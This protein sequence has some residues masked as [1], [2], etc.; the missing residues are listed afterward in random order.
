V[1]KAAVADYLA[2]AR[3]VVN[4][5]GYAVNRHMVTEIGVKMW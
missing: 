4:C 3:E 1:T 5:T 2:F